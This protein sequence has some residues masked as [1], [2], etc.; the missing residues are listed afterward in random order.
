MVVLAVAWAYLEFNRK[1]AGLGNSQP[2]FVLSDQQLLQSYEE[3]EEAANKNYL[4]KI[5]QVTGKV[6]EVVNQ[7]DSATTIVIGNEQAMHKVSCLLQ[8][9]AATQVN[10]ISKNELVTLKGICTGFLM[11][12]ELNQCIIVEIK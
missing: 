6:Y 9:D 10:K 11:D 12:V 7:G 3:N 5:V 1:P 8:Q 2:A 4:G